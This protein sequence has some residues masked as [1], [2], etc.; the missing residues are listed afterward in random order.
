MRF[1]G[2]IKHAAGAGTPPPALMEAMG[3]F[4]KEAFAAGVI[5]ETGGLA[6]TAERVLIRVRDGEARVIDGPFT[7]AKE[8]VG[9]YVIY[10]VP[11]RDVALE[12]SRRFVDLHLRHW[13]GFEFECE[14]REMEPVPNS[15]RL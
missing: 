2:T 5:A 4:L 7:E 6:P 12:W 15:P 14:L 9:G 1:L 11:S 10:E 13:P 3:S 8:V